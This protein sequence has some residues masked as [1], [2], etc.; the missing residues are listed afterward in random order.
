MKIIDERETQ[1]IKTKTKK[2]MLIHL[3]QLQNQI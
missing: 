2:H 3:I 1:K